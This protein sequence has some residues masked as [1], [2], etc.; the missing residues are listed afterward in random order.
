MIPPL[1]NLALAER[2]VAE[3]IARIE[4]QAQLV[5]RLCPGTRSAL[6][7]YQSLVICSET[8]DLMKWHLDIE[9][10]HHAWR[11]KRLIPSLGNSR[12]MYRIDTA[13]HSRAV[14][15]HSHNSVEHRTKCHSQTRIDDSPA[16]PD[17]PPSSCAVHRAPTSRAS[18]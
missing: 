13:L 18:S 8:L 7:A 4:R 3:G 10:E 16:Q 1:G 15:V 6:I 2:H 17:E 5:K 11:N 14:D 9:I 12:A